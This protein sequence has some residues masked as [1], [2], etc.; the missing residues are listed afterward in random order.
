MKTLLVAGLF[1]LITYGAGQAQTFEITVT[2]GYPRVS[3]APLG[4][5]SPEDGKDDDTKLKGDYGYGLRLTV[6]TPGYY[7][8]E[9]GYMRNRAKLST[10]VRTTVD[11]ATVATTLEDTITIQQAFYNFLI[12]FMPKNERFRPFMT[13]GLQ[14]YRYA[15]PNIPDWPTGSVRSYGANYGAGIKIRLFE[16]ALIRADFRD[17]IG[18]KPYDLTF[19]DVTHS[20][21][22]LHQLEASF[23]I[24]IT[25]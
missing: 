15:A 18:G 4:S 1:S 8:H 17:Y 9:F 2:G 14:M 20:G 25:F 16:H 21:G 19:Q 6:N 22:I 12:Y 7:G 3:S 24:A 23:G 11:N 10:I 5:I 13:G